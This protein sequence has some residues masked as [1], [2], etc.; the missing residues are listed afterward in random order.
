MLVVI[1]LV[2]AFP[3]KIVLVITI[4]LLMAYGQCIVGGDGSDQCNVV[5]DRSFVKVML[6]KMVLVNAMQC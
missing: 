1:V 5:G 3:V 6:M 2:N 4:L